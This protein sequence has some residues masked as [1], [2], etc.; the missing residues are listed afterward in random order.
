MWKAPTSS[1]CGQKSNHKTTHILVC[2]LV[3][4]KHQSLRLLS[5]ILN[6]IQWPRLPAQTS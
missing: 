6:K 2:S 5:C 4:I 1:T 3:C